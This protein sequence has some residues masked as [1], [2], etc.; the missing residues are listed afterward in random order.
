MRLYQKSLMSRQ[1]SGQKG[2]TGKNFTLEE[3]PLTRALILMILSE[4]SDVQPS[5][6]F[7]DGAT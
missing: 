4:L 7:E 1:P 2:K 5:A 6:D 3:A